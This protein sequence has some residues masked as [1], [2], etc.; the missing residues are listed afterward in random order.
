MPQIPGFILGI[1]G[2]LV[3]H[4]LIVSERGAICLLSRKRR[5]VVPRSA[6]PWQVAP[7]QS[8]P[9]FY[10]T[11]RYYFFASFLSSDFPF[12]RPSFPCFT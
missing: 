3:R 5:S 11:A 2:T 1:R 8:L 10:R 7:Q 4:S 9:L 6:I 12:S